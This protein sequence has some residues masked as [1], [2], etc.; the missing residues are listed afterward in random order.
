LTYFT[1]AED[2]FVE[3][4][5]LKEIA[6]NIN[7]PLKVAIFKVEDKAQVKQDYQVNKLPQLRFY[8]NGELGSKKQKKSFEILITP[9]ETS[10]NDILEQLDDAMVSEVKEVTEQIMNNIAIQVAVEEKKYAIFYLYKKGKVNIDYKAI[11]TLP[12]FKDHISFHSI[13]QPSENIVMAM[14][15]QKLPALMGVIPPEDDNAEQ[16]QHFSMRVETNYNEMLQ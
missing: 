13:F 6:E 10:L 11:S 2:P 16:L 4:A 1:K 15:I 8:P 7:G 14:Q 3:F 5:A 12:I 9:S